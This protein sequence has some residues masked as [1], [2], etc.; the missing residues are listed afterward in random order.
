MN[1]GEI[2]DQYIYLQNSSCF[3]KR[4]LNVPNNM[5]TLSI[6]YVN[7]LL[8]AQLEGDITFYPIQI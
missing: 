3:L 7:K 8:Y 1:N 4:Q 5:S 2:Y 6:I